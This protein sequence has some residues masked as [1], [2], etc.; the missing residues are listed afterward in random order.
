MY[1]NVGRLTFFKA[2]KRI[3]CLHTYESYTKSKELR[4]N[5]ALGWVCTSWVERVCSV[6]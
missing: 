2:A 1:K 5:M 6:C 3:W 4:L